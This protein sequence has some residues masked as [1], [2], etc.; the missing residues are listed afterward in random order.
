MKNESKRKRQM[1]MDGVREQVTPENNEKETE[2]Y[3][4]MKKRKM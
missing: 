3:S 1:G 2:E 4:V